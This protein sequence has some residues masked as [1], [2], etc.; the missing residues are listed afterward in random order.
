MNKKTNSKKSPFSDSKATKVETR[1]GK[2]VTK[3][4]QVPIKRAADKLKTKATG[5]STGAKTQKGAAAKPMALVKTKILKKPEHKIRAGFVG[6]IGQPNAG[7]S[8]LMN[9]LVKEKVSIVTPQPQTTR[10]RVQG[11]VTTDKGQVIFVD[12]PGI[13]NS[14]SGLNS[15]LQ[16]EAQDVIKNSDA[17]VAVLSIDEKDIKYNTEILDLV[18]ASRKPFMVII[19]K[20]DL[21][22]KIHRV[23]ILTEQFSKENVKWHSVG[24]QLKNKE[25]IQHIMDSIIELLPESDNYLFDE[26]DYTTE[27]IR[28]LAS[29]IIR[30]KCFE[31]LEFEVPFNLA[32]INQ[33]FE[34]E[35]K[36]PR[37]IY[38]IMV[39]KESHKPIVVGKGASKI[40]AIGEKARTEIQKMMG[41]PKIYLE[42]NVVVKDNWFANKNLMKELKYVVRD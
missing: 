40:K 1:F 36:C 22:D 17:L 12:A 25:D 39:S 6:L 13:I 34:E 23:R 27:S 11:L 9:N 15:F 33:K 7:K 14:E 28:D 3:T 4:A 42:L 29:E 8:T 31:E 2:P 38:D 41:V 30:E 16:L 37:L 35:L 21:D 18:K 26:D 20:T 10:R 19:T 32:I 5:P 24:K